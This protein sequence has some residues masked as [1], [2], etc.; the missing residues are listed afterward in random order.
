M[1]LSNNFN[2]VNKIVIKNQ[3][4]DITTKSFKNILKSWWDR[5][6]ESF[7]DR[8]DNDLNTVLELY[9]FDKK[10]ACFSKNY[11]VNPPSDFISVWIK[12]FDEQNHYMC[13][14]TAYFDLNCNMF[15]FV[16]KQ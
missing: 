11:M 10:G 13:E 3:L 7:F 2:E 14:Y 15:D 9:N 4:Y 8:F 1:N 6:S 12:L 16:I 5:N